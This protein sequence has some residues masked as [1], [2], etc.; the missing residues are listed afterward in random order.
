MDF[1]TLMESRWSCRAYRAE[2]LPEE[3][4]TEVLATAQRTP[5]W[6]NTQ[7]WQVHLLGGEAL[8]WFRK[9]LTARVVA[10]PMGVSSDLPLPGGYFGVYDERR[11]EAGYALYASL[12]IERSD[13]AAR[14]A[15]MLQNFDF[16]G[17]PH[18]LIVTTDKVHGTYG[19]VDCG[20]YVTNLMNAALDRGIGSIAQGAIGIQAG[21]VRELLDLP[22]DRLVVCAVALGWPA[23][24]HPVN[25]FRTSR[26]GLPDVVHVVERP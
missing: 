26:A 13:R 9:E 12:G 3:L 11:R 10:D 4:L 24:E 15:A 1:G 20:A 22:E 5:S 17:A 14:A 23:E 16:F 18:A 6:C 2:P 7:P 21:V 8:E 19:A 25:G